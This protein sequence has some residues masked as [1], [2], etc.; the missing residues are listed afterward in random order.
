MVVVVVEFVVAVFASCSSSLLRLLIAPS[1]SSSCRI[2]G[3]DF[4]VAV[5]VVV[6]V[7][8]V[9]V[10]C[11]LLMVHD[12]YSQSLQLIVRWFGCG[13]GRSR[14]RSADENYKLTGFNF[15]EEKGEKELTVFGFLGRMFDVVVVLVRMHNTRKRYV[16]P[17]STEKTV[18]VPD[19]TLS[20]FY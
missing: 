15:W 19:G 12:R 14:E 9:V 17:G 7:V 2:D 16:L 1:S 6:A 4:D 13:W 20:Q 3:D 8:A 18:V 5:V 10:V 11:F